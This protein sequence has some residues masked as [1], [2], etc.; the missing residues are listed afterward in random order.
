MNINLTLTNEKFG[1]VRV[2]GTSDE[3]LFCLSDL[4]RVLELTNIS[5]VKKR[6]DEKG[7]SLTEVLTNGGVQ[8]MIFVNEKNLYKLIMRSDKPQAEPFQDWVCGDVL[9][10]IRK[11]GRYESGLIMNPDPS[12][13]IDDE[14]ERAKAW[15]EERKR[16]RL[17]EKR[18]EELADKAEYCDRVLT[19]DRLFPVKVIAQDYGMTAK[20]FNKLLESMHIQ[21]KQGKRWYLYKQYTGEGYAAFDTMPVDTAAEVCVNLKWTQKGR[22]FLNDFLRERGVKPVNR[23]F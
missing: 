2:A 12:Y 4:C 22:K 21:Y 19:S 7:L 8:Q 10:Q 1:E 13:L 3:P 6:L 15:I 18:A 14:I 23:L 9:P 20:D 11:T 5:E 16:L 17:A